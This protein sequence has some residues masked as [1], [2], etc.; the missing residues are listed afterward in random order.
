MKILFAII[1]MMVLKANIVFAQEPLVQL[2][3]TLIKSSYVSPYFKY[4]RIKYMDTSTA[5]DDL[6]RPRDKEG[7][8]PDA[9]GWEFHSIEKIIQLTEDI[10]TP[11]EMMKMRE[12]SGAISFI[13]LSSGKIVSA[14]FVFRH[15]DP[16]IDLK[17]LIAFSK[18]LKEEITITTLF[19]RDIYE[20]GYVWV[21]LPFFELMKY[22][23]K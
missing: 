10:F 3:D 7:Q 1:V 19:H 5:Y 18:Q 21:S 20:E 16:E 17:K 11:E 13:V 6:P 12:Q 23:H 4:T 2:Q 14:S 22:K 8:I 9:S 15:H